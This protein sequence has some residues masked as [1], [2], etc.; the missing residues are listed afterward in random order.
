LLPR[1]VA[2]G[3]GLLKHLF[4]GSLQIDLPD[5][6]AY[7][8]IDM[9][10]PVCKDACGFNKLKLKLTNK[11]PNETIGSGSVLSGSGTL[12]AVVKFFR[13]NCYMPDLSGEPG[14]TAFT[15]SSCRSSVEEIVVSDPVDTSTLPSEA[16]HYNEQALVK[17][18]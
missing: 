17:F 5:E 15:G 16:L 6:G 18:N 9:A 13:N 7:A 12:F 8:L 10:A 14:G 4:R 2:Y 1:A 11:T 3:V